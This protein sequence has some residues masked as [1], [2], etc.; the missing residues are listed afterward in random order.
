M[1][2]YLTLKWGSL[3]AWNCESEKSIALLNEWASHGT[4]LSAMAHHDTPEQKRILCDLI[5]AMNIET[6][7]LDWD[8][9]D[10][11]KEEAKRYVLEY[12]TKQKAMTQ[13]AIGG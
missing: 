12:G 9:K 10:V 1:A 4:C 7:C 13:T 11:S 5:D 6:V 3:K 2:E 8:G